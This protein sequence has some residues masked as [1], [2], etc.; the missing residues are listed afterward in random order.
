MSIVSDNSKNKTMKYILSSFSLVVVML[1]V[2]S[3]SYSESAFYLDANGLTVKAKDWVVVGTVG[4][5]NGV[6]YV[7]VN[8]SSSRAIL[9]GVPNDSLQF[10]T[11]LMTDM[12]WLFTSDIALKWNDILNVSDWDVSNVKNMSGMFANVNSINKDYGEIEGSNLANRLSHYFN[13]SSFDQEIGQWDVSHVTNMSGMFCGA[14]LFNRYINDW[15]VSNVNNM[16][17]M[18]AG[19][20]KFNQGIGDWDVGEVTNMSAMFLKAKLFGNQDIDYSYVWDELGCDCGEQFRSWDVSRVTNMSSMFSEATEFNRGLNH[21]DVSSVTDMSRMFDGARA[22][23]R[24]NYQYNSDWNISDWDVSHVTNMSGMFARTSSFNDN[25]SDWN[26]GDSTNTTLMLYQ[27]EAFKQEVSYLIPIRAPLETTKFFPKG[28]RN[29]DSLWLF[30]PPGSVNLE[31]YL[32]ANYDSISPKTSDRLSNEKIITSFF[33][34]T[35]DLPGGY[36]VNES[37]INHPQSI[38]LHQYFENDISLS[39]IN[40]ED[41]NDIQTILLVKFPKM[42]IQIAKALL[43]NQYVL[44]PSWW[45]EWSDGSPINKWVM[46]NPN[47]DDMKSFEGYLIIQEQDFTVILTLTSWT[48]MGC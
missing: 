12:S 45:T 16:A 44:S 32:K 47:V 4:E 42:E 9:G 31:T 40:F 23:G 27:A 1:I 26:L 43:E 7:A 30:G 36:I 10:V 18:F 20:A 25:I 46:Y 29:L 28:I 8:D 37:V 17:W 13:G 2:S 11:T 15:N 38:S 14:D 33:N 3:C 48:Y 41:E 6:N 19:A 22:F 5:L 34:K 35:K 24:F 39:T 21:W